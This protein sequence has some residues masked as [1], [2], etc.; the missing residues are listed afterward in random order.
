MSTH[1]LVRVLGYYQGGFADNEGGGR[2]V[3][4][5]KQIQKGRAAGGDSLNTTIQKSYRAYAPLFR[6]RRIFRYNFNSI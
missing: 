1:G 5:R 4:L 3:A 2:G 6:L